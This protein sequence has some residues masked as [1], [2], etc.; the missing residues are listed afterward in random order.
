MR[1]EQSLLNPI[2]VGAHVEG[3]CQDLDYES[4]RKLNNRANQETHQDLS[5]QPKVLASDPSQ[6]FYQIGSANASKIRPN[7]RQFCIVFSIHK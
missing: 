2:K 6:P 5:R 7:Y 4:L 1:I 3:I